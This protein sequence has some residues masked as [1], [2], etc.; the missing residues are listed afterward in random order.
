V[1]R[2]GKSQHKGYRCPVDAV[3]LFGRESGPGCEVDDY[4]A[5]TL[6]KSRRGGV[7]KTGQRDDVDVYHMFHLVDICFQRRVNGAARC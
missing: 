2:R 5:S 6:G 1:K 4:P 7:D 3:E